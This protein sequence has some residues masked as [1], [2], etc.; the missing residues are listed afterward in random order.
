M[1]INRDI[2]F[3]EERILKENFFEIEDLKKE[4]IYYIKKVKD[5]EEGE[6]R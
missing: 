3:T 4:M 5:E 2:L 6:K 1:I